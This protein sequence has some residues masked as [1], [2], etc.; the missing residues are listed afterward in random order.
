M[1]SFVF[2]SPL[3]S[4]LPNGQFGKPPSVSQ[5]LLEAEAFF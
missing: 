4:Q 3:S 2:V 5:T 1:S